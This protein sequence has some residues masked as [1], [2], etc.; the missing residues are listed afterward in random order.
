MA[1][2][3]KER[4]SKQGEYQSVAGCLPRIFWMAFGN[5]ALI[6]A[7]L[8]IYKSAGWSIADF[9]FWLIVGLLI[10]ARYID[11][12]RYKGTTAHGEP[13]TMAHFKRYVGMLL[14][15]GA[16]VWAVARALG[17]GFAQTT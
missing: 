17:P 8:L 3:R 15:A 10:G 7:A 5:I 16:A 14:V 2:D 11:I 13:A 6:M 12:V 4:A 9:A 1:D